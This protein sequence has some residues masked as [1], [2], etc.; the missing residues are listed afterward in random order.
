MKTNL[1]KTVVTKLKFLTGR[2][3]DATGKDIAPSGK[4][5]FVWDPNM[6]GFG[7]RINGNSIRWVCQYRV[8]GR[9][10]RESLGETSKVTEE[11]A[12]KI[13][14]IRFGKAA[15]GIDPV[16]EKAKAHVERKADKLTFG[17]LVNRFLAFKKGEVRHHTHRHLRCHLLRNF[18]SLEKKSIHSVKR[19]DIAECLH[20][21][22]ERSGK[23][24]RLQDTP[25]AA[26]AGRHQTHA[27]RATVTQ[28]F[29]WAIGEGYLDSNPAIGTNDPGKRLPSRTRILSDAEIRTVWEV[30]SER[31][32]YGGP[33]E[34]DYGKIVKLLILT[35]C[36]RE[37]IGGMEWSEIDLKNGT[38]K[39]PPE[40]I[41]NH[42]TLELVLP[43]LAVDIIRKHPRR[44]GRKHVFGY[45]KSDNGPFNNY[46]FANGSLLRGILAKGVKMEPWVLHDLRRTARTGFVRLGVAPH[47]A[48]RCLNHVK[49]GIEGVYD[50][51][52]YA[53]E[54][55]DAL[56]RWANHVASIII[57]ES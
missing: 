53:A 31:R 46:V 42:H 52:D 5:H 28:F 2:M 57:K 6:K 21:V 43:S 11:T 16:A 54:I 13:A 15:E 19:A 36:R 32:W 23:N 56:Q 29:K 47:I 35:G 44:E 8:N 3:I 48:E 41:K 25:K 45:G 27:A 12:R 20:E 10:R 50:Q 18:K 55:K 17:V 49:G 14:T 37:E 7:V 38:L 51:Y 22:L 1:S 34:T 39:I 40:R 24:S 26:L 4:D 9:T 33:G 30:C